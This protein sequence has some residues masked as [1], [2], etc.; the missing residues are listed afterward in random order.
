MTKAAL[1]VVVL[2]AACQNQPEQGGAKKTEGGAV[3]DAKASPHGDMK[4]AS[5]HGEAPVAA[6]AK[7]REPVNPHE[8]TVSGVMRD[9]A[10]PGLNFKVPAEWVRKPGG[11]PMR[12]AEFTL[13]GPGGD[14]E[15]AVFRFA[16][17]GGDAASN[18]AR[19]R[20][21]FTGAEGKPLGEADGKVQEIVRGPLK[22]TV[23]DLA[24]TYVAQVTPGGAERYDDADYRMMSVIVEGSGDPY[25]FKAVGP[26]KTMTLW[27]KP[28]ADFS[29][30]FAIDGVPAAPAPDSPAPAK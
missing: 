18:I 16:R 26:A 2:L 13:P 21:Q 10:V 24:G 15:L 3:V 6:P 29:T 12:L 14:A 1:A 11:S 25:F 23:V 20:S 19:W 27:E 7:Q 22:I 8:V 28:F 5:P 17:G 30:S 9:E 4:P